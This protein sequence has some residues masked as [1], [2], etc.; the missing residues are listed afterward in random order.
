[1]QIGLVRIGKL[2]IN[3]WSL[4]IVEFID[5]VFALFIVGY[6]T[7]YIF[8]RDPTVGSAATAA[9]AKEFDYRIILS[10]FFNFLGAI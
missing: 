3:D 7:G 4:N 8:G 2:V 5:P 9:T 10:L 6:G 1:M